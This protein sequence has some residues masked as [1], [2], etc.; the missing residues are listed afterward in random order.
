MTRPLTSFG[1]FIAALGKG[2]GLLILD[3]CEKVLDHLAPLCERLLR[4]CAGLAIL[5][6]SRERLR[7]AGELVWPVPPLE[8]PDPSRVYTLS[9]LTMVESVELFLD[10]ARRVR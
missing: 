2:R 3:N 5:L 1:E 7:V 8:L 9:Q 6:T 10:R 4:S